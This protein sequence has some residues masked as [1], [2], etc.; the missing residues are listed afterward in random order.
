[1]L[2]PRLGLI[3]LA[4]RDIERMADIFRTLGWPEAPSSEPV[5]RVFQLTNGVAIGLYAAKSY[6]PDFGPPADGFRAFTLC[7]NL[8]ALDEVRSAPETLP[9]VPAVA[10]LG[11]PAEAFWGGGFSGRDPEGNI[12][13][14]AWAEGSAID[15]RGGLTF[16]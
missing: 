8:A 3:T 14:V 11:E 9:N 13:D 10:L 6:E 2:P 5:H 7:V 12:W 1:M 4:C 16:P 15:D